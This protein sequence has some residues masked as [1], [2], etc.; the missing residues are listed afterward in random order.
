MDYTNIPTVVFS[1]PP[2]GT[3]GLT[4]EEARTAFGD[5][6]KVYKTAFNPMYHAVTERKVKTASNSDRVVFIFPVK[7]VV[8]GKEEKVVGMHVIGYGADEMTQGF[9]VAVKMGATKQ[10]LDNTVPIHPTASEEFVT[11]R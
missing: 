11:L 3:V 7:I 9:A 10:D 2:I 8:K 6:V 4:E 1:H 5:Q